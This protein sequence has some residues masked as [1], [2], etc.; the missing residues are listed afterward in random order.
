MK[1]EL[2]ALCAAGLIF[3]ST[4]SIAHEGHKHSDYVSEASRIVGTYSPK[5]SD[6][7]AVAMAAAAKTFLASLDEKQKDQVSEELK[8]GERIRWTNLPQRS[9]NGGLA[10]GNCTERQTKAF[11]DL[12]ATLLSKEGYEKMCRVMLADDQLL[13]GGNPRP[14]FGTEDFFVVVF[15]EPSADEPW[16]FQL[17]GHHLG[18]NLSM[19][20]DKVTLA[21]SHTGA[22]PVKFKIGDKEIR[23][24]AAEND[25]AFEL[26]Q[27]LNDD[28]RRAAV[29][30]SQKGNLMAG[31]GKDQIPEL[32]GVSCETFNAAQKKLL[33]K[34]IHEWVGILPAAQAKA[35]IT[36]LKSQLKET[37]FG[38][39]GG[40]N[41]GDAIYYSIQGPTLF[42]EYA[43]QDRGANHIHTIYRDPTNPYGKQLGAN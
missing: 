10:L 21:P 41:D 43:A 32:S 29:L 25:L 35:R 27:S 19:Q 23:P 20:G 39:R 8:S 36:V 24:L 26:L 22:Q 11:C 3:A 6:H 9:G 1:Q 14:G 38:W 34:L 16:G 12:L 28:Q 5:V 4:V 30:S 31:P 15:G 33:E 40:T 42:I 37:K 13:Q 2:T 17:D 18:L 7:S